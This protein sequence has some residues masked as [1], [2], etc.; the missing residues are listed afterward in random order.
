Y[1]K[2]ERDFPL[3]A[4]RSRHS[5]ATEAVGYGKTM[6]GFHM[7][8]RRLGDDAFRAWASRFNNDYRG[9][10]ASFHDIR[11]TMEAVSGQD[12]ARFFEDWVGRAGAAELAV[13]GAS[14]KPLESGFEVTGRLRQTQ[15]DAP[16]LLEVPVVVQTESAPV[17]ASVRL[18]GRE[19]AF[20]IKSPARPLALHVDPAFDLFRRLDPRE[21]PASIG[22][23]LGE[24]RVVAV[25]PAGAPDSEQDAY[26][27]MVEGWRSEGHEVEV[28]SDADLAALPADRAV[29]LL[30]AGNRF[31]GKLALPEGE[32]SLDETQLR[33]GGEAMSRSGHSFVLTARHPSDAARAIGWIV[34]D[35]PG[36]LPGL[37]RKLP[38]YGKYSYL[39][40]E[41][42]EPVNV[43]KGQWSASDSP[44]R[45]DLRAGA[46]RADAP[47]ALALSTRR[48]LAELPPVFSV[49]KLREHVG[50]LASPDRQ[51]R[52]LGSEGLEVAAAYIAGQFESLGLAPGGDAGTYFQRFTATGTPDRKPREAAN[53]IGVLAGSRPDWAGQSVV[54]GAHYDHLGLGWPDAHAGDEGKVHHGADDNASGV[55]VMLELARDLASA[56]RPQR[57]IVFV[58]FTGEEAGRLG[59]RHYVEHPVFPNEGAI[60]MV[61]LDTVG[62]LGTGR[63]SVLASGTAAEWQHIFR[64]AGYVT[65]VD[66]RIIAESYESSDQKSFIDR[67]VPAVQLFTAPHADYHRPG[68]TAGKVDV[69][70]L[71][72][73]ASFVKEAVAY[74]AERSEP[75]TVT[76]PRSSAAAPGASHPAGPVAPGGAS[77]GRRV[78]LGTVPDFGFPGPGVKVAGIVAGSPAEAAGL[79]E[80]DILVRLAGSEVVSLK[81]YSDLLKTLSAGRTVDVVV[82]REGAHVTLQAT[83]AAR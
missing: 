33:A 61:N 1:V 48:P 58:A 17:E 4:F 62:R 45:V 23:I 25:L 9:R 69:D 82:L 27:S 55:A 31:A 24:P 19:A 38:H 74:L 44:L 32:A 13:E 70:G 77:S 18:E 11:A 51:G 26:R 68:D 46:G 7:L 41:G 14:V 22:R 28:V 47:P 10:Q 72:K 56:E 60:G 20:A 52:G 81:A 16:F 49:A 83:L 79:K 43:L 63:L 3:G 66:S 12:L 37:G 71:V 53:V 35:P 21:S 6:M 59:S 40:F 8:R 54:V 78:S 36:A 65:G 5:A 50:F 73:V 34:A 64:G 29:W 80:G 15:A 57:S 42:T 75:L 39:G 76:I 30:G 67:G 2:T